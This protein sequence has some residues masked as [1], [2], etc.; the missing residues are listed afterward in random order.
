MH[1]RLHNNPGHIKDDTLLT[2]SKKKEGV[3]MQKLLILSD[4]VFFSSIYAPLVSKRYTAK[5]RSKS[6]LILLHTLKR[7]PGIRNR[8]SEKAWCVIKAWLDS[9]SSPEKQVICSSRKIT[10]QCTSD[11]QLQ[12]HAVR[13]ACNQVLAWVLK[14]LGLISD[15]R[16]VLCFEQVNLNEFTLLD[17]LWV[18]WTVVIQGIAFESKARKRQK[19]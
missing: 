18:V 13:L 3:V 11:V 19:H 6:G 14:C 16:K 2:A 1:K 7:V 4:S 17:H 9:F 10:S 8:E 12:F 5:G 15:K